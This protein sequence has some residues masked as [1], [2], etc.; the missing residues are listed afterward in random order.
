MWSFANRKE[1][2]EIL[3]VRRYDWLYLSIGFPLVTWTRSVARFSLAQHFPAYFTHCGISR[4]PVRFAEF[5][6]SYGCISAL[7][8]KA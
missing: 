4:N 5:A 6:A 2:I 3:D 1:L 7:F 8:G